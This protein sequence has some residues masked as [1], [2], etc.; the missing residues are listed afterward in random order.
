MCG[1]A[2]SVEPRITPS[3]SLTCRERERASG[4]CRWNLTGPTAGLD[5]NLIDWVIVGGEVWS[6]CPAD[7]EAWV[8]DILPSVG[9]RV[10]FFFKQWA[11]ETRSEL[12][13]H[14]AGRTCMICLW[15]MAAIAKPLEAR[16]L[17]VR[18]SRS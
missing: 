1:W 5:L 13:A 15:R 18:N 9:A 4:S 10:P 2:F 12:V 17:R 14:A 3:A 8:L 7:A 6:R 11:G 16:V